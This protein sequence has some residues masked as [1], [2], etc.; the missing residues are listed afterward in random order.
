MVSKEES[1]PFFVFAPSQQPNARHGHTHSGRTI[2]KERKNVR[3]QNGGGRDRKKVSEREREREK[4]LVAVRERNRI[5]SER[6]IFSSFGPPFRPLYKADGRDIGERPMPPSASSS[7]SVVAA[8]KVEDAVK[9]TEDVG[10][11]CC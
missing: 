10:C 8:A 7:T 3:Q 2:Q 11:C 5:F 9:V 1:D 4:V 6:F